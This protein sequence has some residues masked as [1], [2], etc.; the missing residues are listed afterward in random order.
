[1]STKSTNWFKA[2]RDTMESPQ[3]V[4]LPIRQRYTYMLLQL[5]AWRGEDVNGRYM[6]GQI[7]KSNSQIAQLHGMHLSSLGEDIAD[8]IETGFL[9]R[10]EDGRLMLSDRWREIEVSGKR[11]TRAARRLDERPELVKLENAMNRELTRLQKADAKLANETAAYAAAKSKYEA[12]NPERCEA[13]ELKYEA[14]NVACEAAKLRYEAA[15]R[16]YEAANW[17]DGEKAYEPPLRV[18]G[19]QSA[20]VLDSTDTQSD[21]RRDNNNGPTAVV[22]VDTPGA[23]AEG[24][25][26]NGVTGNGNVNGVPT[27]S[28]ELD[29]RGEAEVTAPSTGSAEI[30]LA[31]CMEDLGFGESIILLARDLN[32]TA[33]FVTEHLRLAKDIAN[34]PVAWVTAKIKTWSKMGVVPREEWD[35]AEGVTEEERRR[36]TSIADTWGSHTRDIPF[37]PASDVA[38]EALATVKRVHNVGRD[39]RLVV[40]AVSSLHA[41]V[42]V[43]EVRRVISAAEAQLEERAA[44][45]RAENQGILDRWISIHGSAALPDREIAAN[46]AALIAESTG[47][48]LAYVAGVLRDG[49]YDVTDIAFDEL[50]KYWSDVERVATEHAA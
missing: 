6:A 14:A 25:N 1:M 35:L 30:E 26:G 19:A 36:I 3:F 33:Q 24:I 37:P 20:G 22:V 42:P 23:N 44:A 18:S 10:S 38:A 21:S 29:D 5:Y 4:A 17:T 15:K 45:R 9:T 46:D 49:L 48:S 27:S 31:K 8:L 41:S 13:A 28:S 43:P 2:E 11:K 12:T 34:H 47:F 7:W 16:R 40:S 50:W 32:L 39:L